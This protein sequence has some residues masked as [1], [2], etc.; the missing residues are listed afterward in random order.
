M[1]GREGGIELRGGRRY[2]ELR[3]QKAA[4]GS[5]GVGR[6]E[7]T[8]SKNLDRRSLENFPETP[9]GNYL[10]SLCQNPKIMEAV[11]QFNKLESER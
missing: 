6:V 7:S 11:S 10:P 9:S 5:T 1:Y 8:L 3:V 4:T 2:L